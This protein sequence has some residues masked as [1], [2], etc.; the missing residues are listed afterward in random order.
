MAA[1]QVATVAGIVAAALVARSLLSEV[2]VAERA[3]GDLGGAVPEVLVLAALTATLGAARALQRHR[4]QILAEL[5]ARHA[6]NQV[7]AVTSTVDLAAFDEPSFH[8]AVERALLAV[9][10]LPVVVAGLAGLATALAGAAG[11]A[12]ALVVIAP[13]FAPVML[14]APLPLWL[15]ARSRGRAF[16]RFARDTTPRDRQRRYL[17]DVLTDRDAAKEVR[18]FGLAAFLSARRCA[19]WDERVLELRRVADRHL[20]LT[21]VANVAAAAILSGALLGL[22]ALT[23]ADHVSLAGAGA[24]AATVVFLGQRLTAAAGSAGI[25]AE[26]ALF[27]DDYLALVAAAP[28]AAGKPDSA[29]NSPRQLHVRAEGVTFS[30]TGGRAP[31][32]RDVSLEIAPGE[33]VALVG[34][35]G[36]GKTTLAKL[37]AGLY[38]PESGSVTMNGVDTAGPARD[39]LRRSVAVIFQDFI[40][41]ALTA[42]ENI[43]LGAHERLGDEEGIYEAAKRAGAH[44]ELV[45]LPEGYETVL[46]PAFEDGFDLSVG[47]WQRVAIGRALFRD[48]PFVIL[49]EP[50]AALDARA[51]HDL[52]TRIR[53]ILAG[54]S[55]LLISHR[56][57]SVRMADRIHVMHAG[58]IVET[59]THEE[60][61]ARGGRYADLFALQAA[62]YR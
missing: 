39:E 12:V 42:R 61:L 46:D 1:T 21:V 10:R 11:A 50:T 53:E 27:I 47:Q 45:R 57:P 2:L 55:V 5:C 17:R 19:L 28:A 52:F 14:L 30:Y 9:V 15:A 38:L 40:R 25:L 33:V 6:E 18:A 43:A 8:D 20:G 22:I 35:N 31:A 58:R 36:S 49:D 54:Q 51:E 32:L 56:F 7:L 59:G 3:A 4:Q 13:L 62:P 37:L 16:Y 60:L 44:D 34:E 29:G 23:L 41:Y 48:A 26:T 24:A